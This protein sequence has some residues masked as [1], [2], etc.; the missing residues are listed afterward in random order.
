MSFENLSIRDMLDLSYKHAESQNHE[1][2]A[3]IANHALSL[4]PASDIKTQLLERLSISGFYSDTKVQEGKKACDELAMNKSLPW[5]T[6]NLARQNSTY[7]A[8]R[9]TELMPNTK[10]QEVNFIPKY[11]Y[12]PMNPSITMHNG[13]LW[14]VQ[15]SVNYRIRP[16]GSYDMRGDC[17]I[18]TTNYL[19]QL[20]DDLNVINSE[21]ILPPEN[22]QDPLYNMVIGWEDCRLFFWNNEPWCTATV[23]E[24]NHEGFCEI[25]ISKISYDKNNKRRFSDFRVIRPDFCPKQHEKNWMPI[26]TQDNLFFL[27]SHDPVRIID[28]HGKCVTSKISHFAADSFRGGGNLVPFGDGWLALIHESHG[29]PTGT[30][31]YMH[32]FVYYSS[33]GKICKYS[34]AFYLHTLGI[35]FSAGLAIHPTRP[36]VIASFG[37]HDKTSWLASF[38]LDDIEKILKPAS[39]IDDRFN[40]DMETIQWLNIQSNNFLKSV[41]YIPHS[42]NII[43]KINLPKNTEQHRNWD[44]L[45]STWHTTLNVEHHDNILNIRSASNTT[46]LQNLTILDYKNLFEI[47]ELLDDDSKLPNI[48]YTKESLIDTKYEDNKFSYINAISVI[49]RGINIELFFKEISRILK[50][51]GRIFISSYCWHNKN[52]PSANTPVKIFTHSELRNILDIAAKFNLKTETP[53]K[54]VD[55]DPTISWENKVFT[56]INFMLV[57][58]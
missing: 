43:E 6:R 12:A 9:S 11:D 30:R 28:A 23:R 42:T 16:D 54:F 33:I 15:R 41:D 35:E 21:E 49:E 29:M 36:E 2:A 18:R 34:P 47:T 57:K 24:L 4:N 1:A 48:S 13:M 38:T 53:I 8:N 45:L 31:R 7:Y 14:M 55:T 32:R 27:Y 3:V 50:S 26:V 44:S 37:I 25:V 19:L 20:D 51:N 5:Y 46:Y 39:V 17:A 52:K 22:L 58:E 56:L 10:L 40:L